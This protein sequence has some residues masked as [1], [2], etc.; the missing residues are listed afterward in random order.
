M[1]QP[2][3][4]S[5]VLGADEAALEK[6]PELAK[7]VGIVTSRWS[8]LESRLADLLGY[9]LKA[10]QH[11]GTLMYM[12]VKSEQARLAVLQSVA[13]DRLSPGMV[14]KFMKLKERI[15]KTGRQRDRVVHGLWAVSDKKPNSLI[16][17]DPWAYTV[18]NA[19]LPYARTQK[20]IHQAGW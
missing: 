15:S 18:F 7:H 11:I 12:P 9:M 10:D 6:R 14:E 3:R 8:Y 13:E 19:S 2:F 20:E 16:W 4:Q 1:P 5:Q 17:I